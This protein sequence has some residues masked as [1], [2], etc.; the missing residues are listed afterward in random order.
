M[1]SFA[2]RI[3]FIV[4][5]TGSEIAYLISD[6]LSL[7]EAKLLPLFYHRISQYFVRK[8]ELKF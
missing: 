5:F 2:L 6:F 8:D 4:R 1:K 7:K 3:V